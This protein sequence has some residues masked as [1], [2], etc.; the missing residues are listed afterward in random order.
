MLA[1][2]F[3]H[4]N[5]IFWKKKHY[6]G[7]VCSN[8]NYI[9]QNTRLIFLL[10]FKL[11]CTCINCIFMCILKVNVNEKLQEQERRKFLCI[12]ALSEFLLPEK[13]KSI[14]PHLRWIRSKMVRRRAARHFVKSPDRWAER[15]RSPRSGRGDLCVWGRDAR[16]AAFPTWGVMR[17]KQT[18]PRW[19]RDA[20]LV[21]FCPETFTIHSTYLTETRP[22]ADKSRARARSG[23]ERRGATRRAYPATREPGTAYHKFTAVRGVSL[24]CMLRVFSPIPLRQFHREPWFPISVTFLPTYKCFD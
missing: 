16:H 11:I 18:R 7:S 5:I 6:L 10:Y 14:Y 2:I 3:F 12:S 15:R 20:I 9:Y 4:V 23:A 13:L 22:S 17:R 21:K 24:T 1:V 8:S 19:Q